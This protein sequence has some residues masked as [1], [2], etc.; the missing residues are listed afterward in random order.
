MRFATWWQ[1]KVAARGKA[2]RGALEDRGAGVAGKA[3]ARE[4]FE[5]RR[6]RQR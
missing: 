2:R 4:E 5:S 1:Q 6:E 3:V